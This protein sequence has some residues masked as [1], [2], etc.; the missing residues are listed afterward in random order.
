VGAT[1]FEPVTSSVSGI[2]GGTRR[3]AT[4]GGVC[5][6]TSADGGPVL[7]GVVRCDP[8][9]RGPDVAPPWPQRST[10]VTPSLPFEWHGDGTAAEDNAA[11]RGSDGLQLGRWVRPVLD[12][13]E[14]RWQAPRGCAAALILAGDQVAPWRMRGSIAAG[15]RRTWT[16]SSPRRSA[17][18]SRWTPSRMTHRPL[19]NS[20]SRGQPRSAAIV[21]S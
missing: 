4:G 6:A 21:R 20:R 3:P 1:G 5:P 11:Q 15:S 13:H 9:A 10:R 2:S 7:T 12:D 17:L 14:P 8:V 16:L 19:R 18:R